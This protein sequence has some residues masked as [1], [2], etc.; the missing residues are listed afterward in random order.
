MRKEEASN[1]R[2]GGVTSV[3]AT[4]RT[5][6]E[7]RDIGKGKGEGEPSELRSVL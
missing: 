1:V 2:T 5:E 3:A 7:E 6:M 4:L